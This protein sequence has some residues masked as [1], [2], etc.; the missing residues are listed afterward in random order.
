MKENKIKNQ[1]PELESGM[2]GKLNT[3]ESFVV[4]KDVTNDLMFVY[5]DGECDFAE[6][7]DKYGEN[8]E[9]YITEL[10][11]LFAPCFKALN[12][13]FGIPIFKRTKE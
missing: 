13:K 8:E 1:M 3:G 7:F 6:A 12:N 4:V 10:W 9:H 5:D 11:I 2:F